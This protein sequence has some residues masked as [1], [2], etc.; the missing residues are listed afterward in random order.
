MSIGRS[1]GPGRLHAHRR[2]D[3]SRLCHK[4]ER[5]WDYVGTLLDLLTR[6]YVAGEAGRGTRLGLDSTARESTGK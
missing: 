3:E 6:G 2:A 5:L 4:S 1:R